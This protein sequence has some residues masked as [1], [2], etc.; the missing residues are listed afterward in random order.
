MKD[1][2]KG[3]KIVQA[4]GN[5]SR[6]KEIKPESK[7]SIPTV[8]LGLYTTAAEAIKAIDLQESVSKRKVKSNATKQSNG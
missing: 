6:Y 2:Y 4:Q 3:Y 8:L 7:G 5:N 1:M